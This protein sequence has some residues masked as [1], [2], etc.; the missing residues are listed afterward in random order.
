MK[1]DGSEDAENLKIPKEY[2]DL[3]NIVSNEEIDNDHIDNDLNNFEVN[4]DPY[5]YITEIINKFVL[6]S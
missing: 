2:Y 5:I 4:N 6:F 3:L 1:T